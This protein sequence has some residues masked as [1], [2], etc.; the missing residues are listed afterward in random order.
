MTKPPGRPMPALTFILL[1]AFAASVMAQ[2]L[3]VPQLSAASALKEPSTMSPPRSDAALVALGF[4]RKI[5]ARRHATSARVVRI[6]Q[7]EPLAQGIVA[8]TPLFTQLLAVVLR[9]PTVGPARRPLPIAQQTTATGA[10]TGNASTFL[11]ISGTVALALALKPRAGWSVKT[12]LR[13]HSPATFAVNRH[14]ASLRVAQ[15]EDRRLFKSAAASGRNLN[16]GSADSS[17]KFPIQTFQL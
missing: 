15:T 9:L 7:L 13:Y 2:S 12:A 16:V 14:D 11:P 4:I 5:L 17:S 10:V 6:P 3:M 1:V 8:R